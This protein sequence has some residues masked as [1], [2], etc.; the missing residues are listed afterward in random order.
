VALG[1]LYWQAGRLE[2][3]PRL[4]ER[5][6][7]LAMAVGDDRLLGV[8]ES[9]RGLF[10]EHLGRRDEALAAY[11]RSIPLLEAAGDLATLA[12]SLNNRALI[13]GAYGRT[14]EAWADLKQALEVARRLGDP[15]HIGWALGVLAWASWSVDADWNRA[16]PYV[17]EIMRLKRQ[18]R[19]TRASGHIPAAVWLRLVAGGEASALQELERLAEE[20]EREGDV[21]VWKWAQEFLARWDLL[22]GHEEAALALARYEAMLE[23]PGIESQ[24]RSF[25]E[26]WLAR[27]C[28]A[29]GDLER[30]EELLSGHLEDVQHLGWTFGWPEYLTVRAELRAAQGQWEE[31]RADF[32]EALTF[33]L[34]HGLALDLGETAHAY[35]AALARRGET[36]AARRQFEEALTVFRRM[37]AAPYAA[38]TERA[39]AQLT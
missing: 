23:H 6:A 24:Y 27:A 39:L 5:A 15:A 31:A 10:L 25:V 17:E 28:V 11:T 16:R 29:C 8:A 34:E 2:D 38:Q 20:G 19:G 33:A 36:E 1:N 22:Q 4:V 35:G 32:E 13:Y 12:R 3:G 9:R 30:A 18:L 21:A 7:E 26:R 14:S 37:S